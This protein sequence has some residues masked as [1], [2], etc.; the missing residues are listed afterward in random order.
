MSDNALEHVE[1][2][3]SGLDAAALEVV[4]VLAADASAR[5]P[6]LPPS[7][8]AFFAALGEQLRAQ[9]AFRAVHMEHTADALA[10]LE[11][12]EV[13]HQVGGAWRCA[14]RPGPVQ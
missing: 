12:G 4:A 3:V 14:C 13:A 1:L 6:S 8:R 5:M 9:A 2:D 7:A 10:A 11:P